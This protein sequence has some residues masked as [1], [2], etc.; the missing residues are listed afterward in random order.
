MR[1]TKWEWRKRMIGDSFDR[2][3]KGLSDVL[4]VLLL[5]MGIGTTALGTILMLCSEQSSVLVLTIAFGLIV[6]ACEIFS[7]GR[8]K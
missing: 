8:S 6:G 7:Y 3:Y 1:T 2:I 4:G 5:L